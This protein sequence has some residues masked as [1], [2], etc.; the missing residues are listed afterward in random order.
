MLPYQLKVLDHLKS[1]PS[2]WEFFSASPAPE[3][4]DGELEIAGRIMTAITDQ[5]DK[6]APHWQTARLFRTYGELYCDRCAGE[7]MCGDEDPGHP[8]RVRALRLWQEEGE[9][10]EPVIIHMVEGTP[11]LGCLDLFG[12]AGIREQTRRLI[13]EF[14]R[15]EEMRTTATVALAS[16]Y[17]PDLSW[18]EEERQPDPLADEHGSIRDY[19][20]FVLV[21]LVLADPIV[22]EQA[23]ERASAFAGRLGIADSFGHI[24]RNDIYGK[25]NQGPF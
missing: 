8:L 18:E 1:H 20:A 4:Q 3:G 15:P 14:L 17:F 9:S 7:V 13:R 22:K 19:F 2:L 12:Q 25:P 6:G 16:D 23:F 21:D 11:E 24:Y 5:T 10:A